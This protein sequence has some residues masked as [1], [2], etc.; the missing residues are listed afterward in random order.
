MPLVNYC[1]K[2]K[3]ETPLGDSCP[4]CGSKLAQTGEQI[5]FGTVRI[6]HR[7]WFAWNQMLRIVLPVLLLVFG[8]VV[9]AEAAAAGVNGVVTLLKG[10]FL[11]T[12][13]ILA[14]GA[15]VALRVVFK[16]QGAENVHVVMDKN[17]ITVRTYVQQG[18]DAALYARLLNAQAAE[19]LAEEDDR[20]ELENLT[21]VKKSTLAWNAVRRVVIW[22][23]E[24]AVLFYRPALWQAAA[25]RV[26]VE[27]MASAEEFIRK[28]LKRNKKV[29]LTPR[30]DQK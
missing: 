15:V 6:P 11:R 9:A 20:P 7:D 2:C 27:E 12:M 8:I 17:G 13:V 23:E 1:K 19:K 18:N 22:P 25:V 14:V 10:G 21:L 24:S 3:A 16:L 29:R 5:S 30:K 28:K 26:P 4:Y